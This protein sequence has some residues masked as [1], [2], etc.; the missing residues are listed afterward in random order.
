M[1]NRRHLFGIR[2]NGNGIGLLRVAVD[3]AD[4][5]DSYHPFGGDKKTVL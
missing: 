4:F 1:L 3:S 2:T 5:P